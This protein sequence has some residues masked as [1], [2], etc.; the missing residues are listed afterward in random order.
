MKMICLILLICVL[1]SGCGTAA[2]WETVDDFMPEVPASSWLDEAQVIE[3][4]LPSNAVLAEEGEG[5]RLYEADGL[6]VETNTFLASDLR[7]AVKHL[8]GYEE[9][10][11]M[12]L[13]MER[14]GLPEYQFA[15]YAQTEEG[16]RLYRADLVMEGMTCYAVVCSTPEE[17]GDAYE[18][19]SRQVFASFT[20]SPETLV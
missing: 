11:M 13:Q 9:D 4:T 15:W 5:C 7:A 14:D 20:L 10:Q 17:A 3:I 1:L 2:V 12:I 19:Q 18:I 16:G 8:S 6:Q